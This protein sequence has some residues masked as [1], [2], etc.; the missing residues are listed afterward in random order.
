[1]KWQCAICEATERGGV[2]PTLC[3]CGATYSFLPLVTES[4]GSFRR[5]SEIDA[6]PKPKHATGDKELDA[7]MGG[8]FPNGA[9]VLLWGRGGSGKTRCALRW[10]THIGTTAAYSLEMAEEDFVTS[11]RQA[12]AKVARLLVNRDEQADPPRAARC[13]VYDSISEAKDP[14]PV[15]ER[16]KTWASKTGGIVFLICHA[17]KAGQ[18]KGPSTLQHFGEAEMQVSASRSKPGSARVRINKSRFC[19]LGRAV[20]PLVGLHLA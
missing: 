1:M 17:T 9:R 5:A 7:L 16:L 13:V 12:G 18:Y 4:A 19:Q 3:D 8:G 11:A 10:A 20:V 14:G 2:R 15:L 6:T